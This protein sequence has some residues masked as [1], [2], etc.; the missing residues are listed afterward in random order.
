MVKNELVHVCGG[1]TSEGFEVLPLVV[2]KPRKAKVVVKAKGKAGRPRVYNGHHRRIVAAALKKHGLTKGL[3]FLETFRNLK[4]S[5]SV[6]ISVAKEHKL[7]FE[8]GRPK[9]A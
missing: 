1:E 7:T 3:V 5:M 9:A 2:R 6:A 4:V 8:R